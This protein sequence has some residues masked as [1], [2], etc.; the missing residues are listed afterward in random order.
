MSAAEPFG[1]L[2]ETGAPVA[3]SAGDRHA[4]VG[5]RATRAMDDAGTRG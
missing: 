1:M 5:F 3:L 4:P 2:R